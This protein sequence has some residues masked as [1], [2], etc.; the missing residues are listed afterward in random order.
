M[1]IISTVGGAWADSLDPIVQF[2]AD[3]AFRR[4][5]SLIATL[6]NVQGSSRA[7]EQISG[8]GAIGID[9]WKDYEKA[10][11]VPELNFDQGYKATYTHKE[12]P[13]DFAV[14]RKTLDDG[15]F[16]E[17]F[18]LVDRIGDSA[19][20][21]RE[22]EAASVFNNAFTSTGPDGAAL[23]SDSHPLSP[24]KTGTTQDNSFALAL[25]KANVRT[26]REA[27]MAFTDDNGNKMAVTPDLLLVPPALEDDAIEIV[28]SVN[29]PASANN[30]VNPQYQRFRVQAWHYLTDSNAW[31]MIDS[32][33]MRLSLDW[34][35]R[36]PFGV[37]LREGD[38]RT[39][40]AW[41]RA[42]QRFSY[43]WS[44]WKWIAGSNPS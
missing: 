8:V 19:A 34:F 1:P 22:V 31:F 10:R 30:T 24:N 41:W 29:D 15:N 32:A 9:A 12:Y 18:R 20:V 17:V 21:F 28:M 36:V 6:Y 14:E 33:L 42:Y 7:Y 3:Q 39:I 4:R 5:A 44:D 13:A 43:G 37:Q 16:A 2:R 25:T 27:M 11:Q 23:C 35:N 26:V 38:D 40:M